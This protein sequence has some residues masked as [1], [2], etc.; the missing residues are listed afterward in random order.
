MEPLIQSG[1]CKIFFVKDWEGSRYNEWEFSGSSLKLQVQILSE[2]VK[3]SIS[4]ASIK[5]GSAEFN[6]NLIQSRELLSTCSAQRLK[7]S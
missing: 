5:S 4:V 3:V 6:T 1:W 2:S 7:S